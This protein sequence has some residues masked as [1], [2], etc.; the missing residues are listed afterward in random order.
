MGLQIYHPEATSSASGLLSAT[1]KS[2]LDG[3][4]TTTFRNQSFVI[5]RWATF[6]NSGFNGQQGGLTSTASNSTLNSN[7]YYL[8]THD[9]LDWDPIQWFPSSFNIR[10]FFRC[11]TLQNDGLHVHVRRRNIATNAFTPFSGTLN[12]FR[13]QG[14][15]N[16]EIEVTNGSSVPVAAW[17]GQAARE[18][19]E[20][21]MAAYNGGNGGWVGEI[22]I[23]VEQA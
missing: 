20:F 13:L 23:K 21:W 8:L 19:L 7:G 16:T 14:T 6:E 15:S 18:R 22:T 4:F 17:G 9:Y 3:V 11:G 12:Y 1:D 10:L 2:K 5:K